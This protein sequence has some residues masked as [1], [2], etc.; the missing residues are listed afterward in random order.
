MN[1]GEIKKILFPFLKRNSFE[2]R[3]AKSGACRGCGA[4]G[5]ARQQ[6]SPGFGR[7]T[8]VSHKISKMPVCGPP[9]CAGNW[10][11]VGHKSLRDRAI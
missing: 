2:G 1:T 10:G 5:A 6:S 7:T 4:R 8:T 9:K 11:R 3:P